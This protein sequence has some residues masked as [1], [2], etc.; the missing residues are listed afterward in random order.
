MF[1]SHLQQPPPNCDRIVRCA[2]AEIRRDA[3]N[4]AM[5]LCKK[6][7]NYMMISRHRKTH[8]RLV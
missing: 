1:G 5:S 7:C 4:A 2:A 8:W 3:E 6:R